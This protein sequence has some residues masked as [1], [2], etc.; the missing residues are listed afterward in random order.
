[1]KSYYVEKLPGEKLRR[2]YEIAP[3]RIQQY[4]DA[5]I[6]RVLESISSDCRVL[7]LGCGYGRVLQHLTKKARSVFGI[8]ISASSIELARQ[9][10]RGIRTHLSSIRN[11]CS[12]IR[13]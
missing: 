3:P 2:C 7:E 11:E 5:E 8:D 9:M 12:E 4:L 13:V 10:L 1:M 6:Q